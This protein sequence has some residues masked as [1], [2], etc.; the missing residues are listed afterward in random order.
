MRIPHR[1]EHLRLG[2]HASGIGRW[3]RSDFIRAI[4]TGVTP[5]GYE[6]HSF[7]PWRQFR[8]MTD[9]DLNAIWSYLRTLAPVRNEVPRARR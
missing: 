9:D 5:D 2:Q 6:L 8:R 7:M 3:S 1:N 4:R